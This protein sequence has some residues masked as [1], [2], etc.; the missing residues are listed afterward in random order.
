MNFCNPLP[1]PYA[2]VN[3]LFANSLSVGVLT[4]RKLN[5]GV[6]YILPFI[7]VGILYQSVSSTSEKLPTSSPAVHRRSSIVHPPSSSLSFGVLCDRNQCRLIYIVVIFILEF[8]LVSPPI[9][10]IQLLMSM[11][12]SP[13]SMV[14]RQ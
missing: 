8:R 3:R 2:M 12:N 5:I 6:S 14:Y 9:D 1:A 13:S 4:D 7:I 11:V 10:R